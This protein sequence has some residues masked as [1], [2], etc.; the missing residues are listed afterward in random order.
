MPVGSGTVPKGGLRIVTGSSH[1]I[2]AVKGPV[3]ANQFSEGHS[4][5]YTT[6][7]DNSSD[8]WPLADIM[9]HIDLNV[10]HSA[11]AGSMIEL[12]MRAHDASGRFGATEP[13][14]SSTATDGFI[15]SREISDRSTNIVLYFR[16]IAIPASKLSFSVRSDIEITSINANIMPISTAAKR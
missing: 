10:E 9:L 1:T 2:I 7:F 12:Y 5:V 14:P 8:G 4:N 13:V 15:G 6:I 16:R 11:P 3:G